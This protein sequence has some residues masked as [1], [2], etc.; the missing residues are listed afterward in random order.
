VA[1]C[2][3]RVQQ[4]CDS[5][6]VILLS[7]GLISLILYLHTWLPTLLS[8]S[9]YFVTYLAC[10]VIINL[11]IIISFC[12]CC[13]I[14]SNFFSPPFCSYLFSKNIV[15]SS[16][17][18]TADLIILFTHHSHLLQCISLLSALFVICRWLNNSVRYLDFVG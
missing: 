14:F 6:Q 8:L 11:L 5:L 2:R 1:H 9:Q 13:C 12:C 4:F 7:S 18:F 3:A 10:C 17:I 16:G 15:P